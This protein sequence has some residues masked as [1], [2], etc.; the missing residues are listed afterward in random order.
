MA[1]PFL[2]QCACSIR[3]RSRC[4]HTQKYTLETESLALDSRL[5][6]FPSKSPGISQRT[7]STDGPNPILM[8]GVHLDAQH[9]FQTLHSSQLR[10]YID[11]EIRCEFRASGA[12]PG[13]IEHRKYETY[14]FPVIKQ[15]T[16]SML[17][18]R[19]YPCAHN[20]LYTPDEYIIYTKNR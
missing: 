12:I 20:D 6:L 18:G 1:K 15:Y 14:G 9:L 4:I 3:I 13:L 19:N 17:Q 11:I 8:V 10:R 2:V 7:G 5:I 16:W